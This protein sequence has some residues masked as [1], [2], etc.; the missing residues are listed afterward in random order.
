MFYCSK[1]IKFKSFPRCCRRKIWVRL[2]RYRS[3][4]VRQIHRWQTACCVA[5]TAIRPESYFLY[6]L[7]HEQI[8]QN[9]FPVGELEKPQVRKIAES[10]VWSPRREKRLYR[11][12]QH[13]GERKFREFTAVISR[14]NRANHYRRWRWGG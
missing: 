1:E 13:I 4:Y 9:L 6:T 7:G 11:Y 3:Y 5:R 14:R 10:Q 12:H 2:Y 8:A